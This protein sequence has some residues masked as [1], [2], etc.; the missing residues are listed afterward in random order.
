MLQRQLQEQHQLRLPHFPQN[1]F[2]AE[3]FAR[4]KDHSHPVP[5][6]QAELIGALAQKFNLLIALHN[7]S[8]RKKNKLNEE[9]EE[10]IKNFLE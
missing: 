6:K 3:V 10:W 9:E 4:L 1:K 8:G 7:K 5:E 2:C